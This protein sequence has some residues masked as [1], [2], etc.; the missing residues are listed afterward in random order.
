MVCSGKTSPW[1]ASA[2]SELS[3]LKKELTHSNSVA[4][5]TYDVR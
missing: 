4:F 1:Y 3:D 5:V 2:E